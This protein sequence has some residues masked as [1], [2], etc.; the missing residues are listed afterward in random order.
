M[1]GSGRRGGAYLSLK[2]EMKQIAIFAT[3]AA[4]AAAQAP[5][6]ETIMERVGRN[7]A[8]AVAQRQ[9]FTFRQKQLLRLIRGNGKVAREE[10]REYDVSPNAHGVQKELLR[11]DGRYEYKG[12][13]VTYDRAGYKY[14]GL[15]VDGDLI[16]DLSE[17]TTNDSHSRDGIGV[18]LFPL[19]T[20]EQR[21]YD[22]KLLATEQYRGRKVYRI[23]FEPKP[24]QDLDDASWKGEALIE[25]G[26]AHV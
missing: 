20:Q 26:R 19:T 18:D 10:N 8:Q 5:D 12:K 1:G 4:A 16:R 23:R 11:L 2:V 25:I 24:H 14:K 7:Q 9:E 21:K 6:V 15:D 17:D 22:F 13:Y 3:L